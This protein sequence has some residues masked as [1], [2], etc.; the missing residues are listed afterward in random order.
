MLQTRSY[1][2]PS[3]GPKTYG[4]YGISKIEKNVAWHGFQIHK[5]GMDSTMHNHSFWIPANKTNCLNHTNHYI[6]FA[7][8]TLSRCP[9]R[10][11]H[12][13]SELGGGQ[14]V[15]CTPTPSDSRPVWCWWVWDTKT[16]A[17]LHGEWFCQRFAPDL[18]EE[19]LQGKNLSQTKITRCQIKGSPIFSARVIRCEVFPRQNCNQVFVWALEAG[20]GE[21]VGPKQNCPRGSPSKQVES[22][23]GSWSNCSDKACCGLKGTPWFASSWKHINGNPELTLELLL[24][25]TRLLILKRFLAW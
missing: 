11:M 25:E 22:L 23:V 15:N 8:R 13:I 2:F 1:S 9:P 19:K 4:K 18:S 7:H 6:P 12:C 16:P 5:C 21:G 20:G 10:I 3:Q 14:S 17:G 24:I